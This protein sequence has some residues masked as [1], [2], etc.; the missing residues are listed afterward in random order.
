MPAA[1]IK[2]QPKRL[3]GDE[4]MWVFVLGDLLMFSLLF[5]TYLFYRAQAPA[6]YE[7]AQQT[8]NLALGTINTLVLLT[9]SLFV[10]KALRSARQ[11]APKTMHTQINMAIG[12][13]ALFCTIKIIEYA[14][15][16]SADIGLGSGEFFMFF[17]MLTGIHL[18]HVLIGLAALFVTTQRIASDPRLL[19]SSAIYWHLVDLLWV[20]LFPLLYLIRT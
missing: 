2:A 15:K 3:P 11:G 7:A 19:E 13:G 18:V 16:A 5:A 20:V 10:A 8:L 12:L 6:D 14:Q 9:S 4:G 1:D 17:F